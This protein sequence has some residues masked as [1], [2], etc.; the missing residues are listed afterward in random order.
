[1]NRLRYVATRLGQL[2]IVLLL[3]SFLTFLLVHLL[4]GD[5]VTTILGPAGTAQ[6]RALLR[7]QLGL[8]HSIP[9]G[10]AIW[11]WHALQGNLGQ[12]YLSH[13]TVASAISQALPIDIEL[14]I[15]SQVLALAIA[16]PLAMIAARRPGGWL[17]QVG[18]SVSFGMLAIPAFVTGVILQQLFAVHYHVFPATG[19]T[20]LTSNFVQNVRDAALPSITVALAS[21]A[22]Y[23]RLL[24]AEMINTLQE[25]FITMARS[26]G[27]STPR[28]LMRHAFRPSTFPL[29]TA[30]GLSIA[31]V[32]SSDF[33]VEYIFQAPGL[34][35]QAINAIY[36]RDYLILQGDVLVIAVLFVVSLFVVNMLYAVVDP[37]TRRA[38]VT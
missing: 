38:A 35:Y 3:V 19:W 33:V 30:A 34:G 21:V 23:M 7:A 22:G 16:I 9:V 15:I 27:L 28:I 24:R 36:A 18:S 5:P 20:S 4:P 11:L 17:D 2:V 8:D 29:L 10:Y 37:R 32:V 26:K 14:V 25:D 12:S 31:A 1:M 13:Q 6:T